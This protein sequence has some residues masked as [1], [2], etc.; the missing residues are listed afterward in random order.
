MRTVGPCRSVWTL[1]PP[2]PAPPAR[3]ARRRR[4][5]GALP[6]PQPTRP[7]P[8]AAGRA[9]VGRARRATFRCDDE[10]ANNALCNDNL[11]MHVQHLRQQCTAQVPSASH[12]AHFLLLSKSSCGK[13][14]G[15]RVRIVLSSCSMV[16]DP[17][18]AFP[19]AKESGVMWKQE[20]RQACCNSCLRS[21]MNVLQ[22]EGLPHAVWHTLQNAGP[23]PQNQE[24]HQ[25]A[26]S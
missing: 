14:R 20:F 3:P 9:Y 26:L 10:D 2:P 24:P 1:T 18:L 15:S 4:S 12:P 16:A 7:C 23:R 6:R 17:A 5:A 13:W 22:G 19:L 21:C 8:F 11:L 25:A